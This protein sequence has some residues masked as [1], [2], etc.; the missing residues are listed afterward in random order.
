[1]DIDITIIVTHT[2]YVSE[3]RVTNYVNDF[4]QYDIC[5]TNHKLLI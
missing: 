3:V 1:M 2:N 4:P 5:N